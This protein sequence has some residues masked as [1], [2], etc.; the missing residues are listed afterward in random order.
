MK[1]L[2]ITLDVP[3][4]FGTGDIAINLSAVPHNETDFRMEIGE[5]T[6]TQTAAMPNL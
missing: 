3:D 4:D 5:I 2:T 1:K 6:L